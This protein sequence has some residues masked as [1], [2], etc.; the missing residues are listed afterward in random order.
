MIRKIISTI[1]IITH[2]LTF[3][4]VRDALAFKAQSPSFNLA[5]GALTQGGRGHDTGY[6][7]SKLLLHSDGLGG[8]KNFKDELGNSV[9]AVGDAQI[10]TAQSKFGGS[11]VL[12][13]NIS[14]EPQYSFSDDFSG[15]L[16]NWTPLSGSWATA[17]GFMQ[18]TTNA[19]E[20]IKVTNSNVLN[21]TIETVVK[22]LANLTGVVFRGVDVN[23]YYFAILHS[24]GNA[25]YISKVVNGVLT[26]IASGNLSFYPGYED[27][28]LKVKWDTEGGGVR[29]KVWL[30]GTQYIDYLETTATFPNAGYVGCRGYYSLNGYTTNGHY[31]NS[32]SA[33]T[34]NVVSYLT[35]P[36]S[37]DWD[38]G[39]GNFTI[40]FWVRFLSVTGDSK[41][42]D[43]F[44][45]QNNA[46]DN[47]SVAFQNNGYMHMWNY[48][49]GAYVI[50]AY[51]LFSA[52]ANTWYHVAMVR[53]GTGPNCIQIY[54]DG[55]AQSMT[56]GEGSW[57]GTF[58]TLASKLYIGSDTGVGSY[59]NG[60]IDE[61]R[62]SKGVA[63]WTSNFTPP[64][65]AY[66]P[67]FSN[68]AFNPTLKDSI[69]EPCIGKSQ[70]ASYILEAGYITTI[71]TAPPVQTQII[72]NQAWLENAAKAGVFDL[73]NYFMSPDGA[74]LTYSASGTTNISA[75]ID[76]IKHVV[77]FSQPQGWNG[78]E[79]VKFSAMDAEHNIVVGN[80]VTLQVEGVDNPPVLDYIPDMTVNEN[81]L[82]VIT[83]H[84]TDLDKD[85]ITYTFTTPLN[86][87]GQWQTGYMDS[88]LYTVTVTATDATSLFATQQVHINVKNVNRP[89]VLSNIADIS[90]NEG[91]LVTITP[92]ATD[93]D[94]DPITFYYSAPF[95]TTGKWLTGYNDAGTYAVTVTAS[96]GIDTV[97][98]NV[99]VIIA[100]T[101]RA[102]EANLTINK[103]TASPNENLTVTLSAS[104]PDLDPMTYSL[105]KDS[106][107]IASGAISDQITTNVSFSSVG[108]HTLILTVTDPGSLTAA[109]AVGID[110]VDPN[111]NNNTIYPVMGDFNGDTLMDLG[112]FHSDT[113][114]WEIA[115]SQGGTFTNAVDWLTSFGSGGA[116]SSVGGDFNADGKTDVGIYNSA[117]G[118]FKPALSSGSG[119]TA[120]SVWLTFAGAS[121]SWQIFTGNFNA[122]KFTDLGFYNKNTGE[123]RAALG[124][125]SGFG[126]VSTWL[127]SADTGYVAMP[128]DFNADGLSD[129]CLFKKSAGEFKIYFS[130]SKAF[131]DGGVWISGYATGR[132]PLL[133]DFNN[134]GLTDVGFWDNSSFVWNYAISTGSVFIN[135]GAWLSNFGAV[136]D[137]SATT[138]DFN[139]DGITDRALFD[140]DVQGI[141][142]WKVQ[143]NTLKPS[144][145]M[146]EVDNGIGGKTKV[147]Y[148]YAAKQDNSALP[149]PVYVAS[150]ISLVDTL[151]IGQTEEVYTQNFAYSGGYYDATDREFRGFA[152]IRVSDPIT[153]NY[154]ETY[155]Y[156]GKPG[157]DGALKGQIDKSLAFDGNNRQISQ[158]INTYEVRKAGPQ[159]NVLGFPMLTETS[160]TIWEENGT[161]I[162][163]K[164]SMVYDNI[165]NVTEAFDDGDI[166]KTGDEKSTA[167]IYSPAYEIGHNRPLEVSL[168]DKGLNVISKKAFEYD[169]KGN[170]SKDNVFI[171][172]S[173]NSLTRNS[174]TQY[175]Y[176]SFG[177]LASSTDALGR[178]VTTEYETTFYAYPQ[179]VTNALGQCVTYVYDPKLGV[180]TS[181]T[182]PNGQTTT[183]TYDAFGRVIEAK[184]ADNQTVATNSYPDFNTKVTTN[185]IGLFKTEYVDGLGRKY[186]GVSVGEDGAAA[187]H[188]TS[189]VYYNDRGQ[190]EKESIAH[191]IDE[192]PAQISYVRYEYDLRGRPKK[193]ISDFPGTAKDAESSVNYIDPLYTETTDPQGHKKGALKDVYGNAIEVTEFTSGGVFK[194][195]YEYDVQNNLTKTTDS[196]SNVTQI[197]YDSIGRKLKMNDPD[198]GIWTYEYDLLGNLIRQTD[199][200]NQVLEFQYD[201]LNRLT[202]KLTAGQTLAT[203][204][205]DA[206]G[207]PNC[208]GRLSKVTDQSGSTEFF[209]DKFGREIKST[210]TIGIGTT[211]YTVE[212]TYDILDRLLTLKYP[213]GEIVNYSYD[214]NSGLLEKVNSI[215]SK[216]VNDI[217]YNAKGQI[218]AIA[219]GNNV[220]TTYNYGQDLR[221]SRILTQG[222]GALQDLNYTFDKNGNIVT[223]ADNLRSNIRSY[224]Y[225]D[226]DRLTQ[227]QNVPS[228]TGGYTNFNYQYDSIGNMTY[229]SDVGV[230][231]YGVSAGPHAVTTAGG[232]NYAYDG[233]GNM[234]S[235]KNKSM[236]YD[237]ENRIIKVTQTGIGS[238]TFVYDG[239]G[240]RVK[241]VTPSGSTTYIGSLFEKQAP[242]GAAGTTVKYIY[243]GAN[244]VASVRSA[245]NSGTTVNY[246][247]SDHLGSSS[248]VTDNKG[249]QVSHYEYTPYGSIATSEGSDV[250][251][252][253][254][255]GKELDATGMYFYGARYYDPEIGRFVTADTIV[256]APYDPQSFNRY[257]YCRN[258]PLNYVDPTG[259]IFWF[260]AAIFHFVA[261]AVVAHP[262]IAGA[263]IGGILGGA[264]AAINGQNIGM[265][266]G[267][268]MF[269]GALGGAVGMGIGGFLKDGIGS[270]WSGMVGAGLGGAAAGA[271]GSGIMGGDAGM[272]ALAGLAGGVIGYAGGRVW[273]LGAD[274]VAGGIASMIQ[275]GDFAE[276]AK[277]GAID[278]VI[279]TAAGLAMPMDQIKNQDVQPGDIAYMKADGVLGY[280]IAFLE[281]GPFSH[282]KILSDS[283]NWVSALPRAGVGTFSKASYDDQQAIILRGF[284]GNKNV[285]NAAR[286]ETVAKPPLKYNYVFGG[287]GR[288]CSTTCGN[289]VSVGGGPSWTGI[290]PNSQYNTLKTYGE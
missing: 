174:V 7:Y 206:P 12:F 288:V 70:S 25:V 151:P 247:H 79:K 263:V 43:Y 275:G 38:F 124:N 290:G 176:D 105:K 205:Y 115:I 78:A 23:N 177:N 8:S 24:D 137:E 108:D 252:Y 260:I 191:Y 42:Y 52:V 171:F 211:P 138:G 146:I 98:K 280:G 162:T 132:D 237:A 164:S 222:S 159:N 272:G 214:T 93:A 99:N 249:G 81:E 143:L 186:K 88:G 114:L 85:A 183:T 46:G 4:F 215:S 40:D 224:A 127:N 118:E 87:Q 5:S 36:D 209:Y 96:D 210:K 213:D 203:Y 268:G 41:D 94:N 134:D 33:Q 82:V 193:T 172:D 119:F 133:S 45:T 112:L 166:A 282:V 238:T 276:G 2:I 117:T 69:G 89:P 286:A 110:I 212:R 273:P 218:K 245:G 21:G 239:D 241:Q 55:V 123:V 90:A 73:D 100:N 103:Y 32:F 154:T 244:K 233:N 11:S 289:A 189:E 181:V 111:I 173:L 259:H 271:A 182:D 230:M 194:T 192:D 267:M 72:P 283:N 31:W 91:G 256:Q 60:W 262:I 101:N 223:L 56:L 202:G 59:Y 253:K 207:K 13:N 255:T 75:S 10:D 227:A 228:P 153:N 190:V 168:K 170:I 50:H 200:K 97:T 125:G 217:T 234:V 243:A 66:G 204:T 53:N 161:S 187:R 250:T 150:S 141:N 129:M 281:G 140:K 39:T 152:K 126:E 122:D 169:T 185:A 130:N 6:N 242:N 116:W 165:G 95:D 64:V 22:S 175:S 198:M 145:L 29:F 184:N 208:I 86:A 258:N 225:D 178:S 156:Q 15:S 246:Y 232:Y 180:I 120:Q 107:E 49:S 131:V 226:L 68:P 44:I 83:P 77:S 269:S 201:A 47:W 104:D 1:L 26:V 160:T 266:I 248:V 236:E 235:G 157:Q 149:F 136:T 270:F 219:Y 221:L 9:T 35:V 142:R 28:T 30:G 264:N 251:R 71:K 196:K 254:F 147:A 17:G 51:S 167:T 195:Q 257:S 240:G 84:A 57:N 20:V 155:F 67:D 109:Q 216:Y 3:G 148:S 48:A 188:V 197:W 16:A 34:N 144:D 158:A 261:A 14:P 18:K 65:S 58:P 19:H 179:K 61:M 27:R 285:I 106:V 274:A 199:A 128:G 37:T 80:E 279:A 265:G 139:G 54:K 220:T 277:F 278:N 113:G 231:A 62:I 92:Q 74:A 63:R 287:R 163:N 121:A 284:R 102:P 76:P 135:K 229:K